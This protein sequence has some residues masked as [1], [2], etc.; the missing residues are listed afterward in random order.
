MKNFK[1]AA[2]AMSLALL[3]T[4]ALA[5]FSGAY[6]FANWSSS[7]GSGAIS[8]SGTTTLDMWSGDS[9][10]S[11]N[12]TF[13]I[14]APG[15]A[16]ISFDWSYSTSDQDGA[17]FDPFLYFQ[18]SAGNVCVMC[19]G[20]SGSGSYSATVAS[21]EQFGFNLQTTDGIFGSSHVQITN[22]QAVAAVPEPET[23]AMLLAGLG[24]LGFA[25]RR[26]KLK[27]AA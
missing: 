22:F 9:G 6:S 14:F 3:S 15:A 5:D 27:L 16:S 13:L 24:L 2:I 18:T 12:T 4:P 17:G 8:T 1:P 26:R 19:S 7:P 25:A 21:L 23:Y 20:Y 11:D 10:F